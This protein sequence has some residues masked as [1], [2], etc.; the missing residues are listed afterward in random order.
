MRR[1]PDPRI[2]IVGAGPADLV[3][4]YGLAWM[5]WY[6]AGQMRRPTRVDNGVTFAEWLDRRGL[7]ALT[8]SFVFAAGMTARLYGPLDAVSAH[9]GL[10]WMRRS[11]LRP[12]RR[13]PIACLPVGFQKMWTRLAAHL[14]YPVERD[15]R[16]DTVRPVPSSGGRQVELLREGRRIAEPFDHVFLACPLDCLETH[17]LED[18]AGSA[19]ARIAHPLSAALRDA[20]SPFD[21][22]EVYSAAWRARGWP[23]HAPSRCHLPA[24]TTGERGP[25]LT[26]RRCGRTGDRSVGQ[27]CSYAIADDPRVSDQDRIARHPERLARN[28]DRV[29]SDMCGIVGLRDVEIVHERLWRSNVR[30]SPAQIAEG[31]PGSIDDAQGLR[32]VWYTGGAL[33]HWNVESIADFNQTLAARFARRIGLPLRVRRTRW[34]PSDLVRRL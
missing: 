13:Q 33:S 9:N 29:I 23:E 34:S 1:R 5:R 24:A 20:Y 3:T 6:L 7:E 16:V 17:P 12:G 26:I 28:R 2:A 22:T 21:S 18:V 31:L 15:R 4:R 8:Q 32:N 10:S 25:L 11:L 30:Y 27:L 14:G 19:L